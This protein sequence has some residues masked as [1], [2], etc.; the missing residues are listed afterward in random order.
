MTYVKELANDALLSGFV[1][2]TMHREVLP[3]LDDAQV[4]FDATWERFLNPFLNHKMADITL[5]SCSK[6]GARLMPTIYDNLRC[7][8]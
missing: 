5:N 4:F 6:I 1:K 7:Q 8:A 3:T 2:Q